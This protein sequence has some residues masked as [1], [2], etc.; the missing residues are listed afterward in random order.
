ML[1][2]G[3]SLVVQPAASLP[4][5]TLDNRGKIVIV[6]NMP[7]PLDRY[8]EIRFDDLERCFKLI[9]SRLDAVSAGRGSAI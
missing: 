2:L 9:S 1:V 7:T 3:S 4:L 6:N 5:R 8:A